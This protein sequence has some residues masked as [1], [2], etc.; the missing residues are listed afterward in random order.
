MFQN[1]N[2][3][4]LIYNPFNIKPKLLYKDTLKDKGFLVP[5][6]KSIRSSVN[7]IINKIIPRDNNNFK[8]IPDEHE[9]YT[10]IN[11]ENFLLEK[12][13]TSVIF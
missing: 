11:G 5:E 12:L 10:T 8:D 3:I 1:K 6:Y 13:N 9:Y 7:R 4:E 2:K